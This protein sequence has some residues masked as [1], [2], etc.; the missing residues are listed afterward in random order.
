MHEAVRKEAIA[1]V[2]EDGD[3]EYSEQRG[4]PRLRLLIRAAKLVSSQGEYLCVVRDASE[5]GV[6]V[7][8]FH[9]LPADDALT[10]ELQNGDRYPLVRVW[11]EDGKAGFQFENPADLER[12]VESPS[13]FAKR[14]VRVNVSLP[15]VVRFGDREVYAMLCNLSQQGGR[16]TTSE[17]LSLVQR[18]R[19]EADGFPEVA[20]K[21]RWR[22]GETYGLSFENN[23]QFEELARI[24]FDLQQN[25][26]S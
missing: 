14:A 24:A 26:K 23:L 19:I 6:S 25:Q 9:P 1:S 21:V 12:I 11:E 18:I 13:R 5:G 22:R 2:T 20:A 8:L 16:I 15:C 7:R 10:L 4:A 3:A 17:R